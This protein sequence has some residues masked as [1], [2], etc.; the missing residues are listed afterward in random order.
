MLPPSDAREKLL[1]RAAILTPFA[2]DIRYSAAVSDIS[3]MEEEAAEAYDAAVEFAEL[4][5]L[6]L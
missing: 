1:I 6:I 5:D 4:L 3:Y 2:V